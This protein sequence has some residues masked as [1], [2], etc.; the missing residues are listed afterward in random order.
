MGSKKF[1]PIKNEH[2]AYNDFLFEHNV[3]LTLEMQ[4]EC[5]KV[6]DFKSHVL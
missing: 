6:A 2:Q 4:R 1:E 5:L 3:V